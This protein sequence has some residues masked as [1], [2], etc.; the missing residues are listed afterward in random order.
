MA[1]MRVAPD[2]PA[3][4]AKL[5]TPSI[6]HLTVGAHDV[7]ANRRDAQGLLDAFEPRLELGAIHAPGVEHEARGPKTGAG[8]DQRRPAHAAPDRQRDGGQADGEGQAV[9]WL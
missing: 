1:P 4:I 8:V 5:A 2:G 3:A 6:H 7:G 9:A